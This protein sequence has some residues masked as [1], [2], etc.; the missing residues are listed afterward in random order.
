MWDAFFRMNRV[1]D[2]DPIASWRAHMDELRRMRKALNG[3]RYA[4]LRYRAPG[5]D[6][7]VELPEGHI[8]LGGDKDNA[9]GI[10]FVANMPTEEVYTMPK[11]TGV[12]GTVASTKPLNVNGAIVDRF[13][14]TFENGRVVRYEA[15]VGYEHLEQLMNMDEGSR[16]LGERHSRRRVRRAGVPS[17][18]LGVNFR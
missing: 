11:R 1:Y 12:N 9:S 2:D 14:F 4:A 3:K 17:R 8:W 15:E 5:T 10:R 6:L 7:C 13:R 16:Y 18:Q